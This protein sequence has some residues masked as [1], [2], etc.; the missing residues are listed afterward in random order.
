MTAHLAWNMAKQ[1][2]INEILSDWDLEEK[3]NNG[4]RLRLEKLEYAY[5]NNLE[6]FE[7]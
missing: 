4:L 3:I 2:Y 7:L 6:I 5:K 1:Q